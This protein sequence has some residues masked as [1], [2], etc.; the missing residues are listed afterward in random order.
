M[1]FLYFVELLWKLL[2]SIN[3][4]EYLEYSINLPKCTPYVYFVII[5]CKKVK[6]IEEHLWLINNFN[7][8]LEKTTIKK[9]CNYFV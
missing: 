7:R 5:F 8:K 1:Q 2:I 4:Y 9:F 3:I 6:N